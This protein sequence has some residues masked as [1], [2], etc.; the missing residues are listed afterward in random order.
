MTRASE[1]NI[2]GPQCDDGIDNDLDGRIDYK[3]NGLGD[4][5]CLSSL[6]TSETKVCS[7]GIDN[8]NDGLK[9]YP[10]DPGCSSAI[11][12][13]ERGAST[14]CDDGIDNDGDGKIDFRLDGTGDAGCVGPFGI[15]EQLSACEDGIDNDGDSLIDYPGDTG[16]VSKSDS[17]EREAGGLQCDNGTDDD[18]D[19]RIDFPLD[20]G[21]NCACDNSETN[22]AGPQC[23]NGIEDD[24]D[25]KVDYRINGSGD[26]GCSGP[27][28]TSEKDP[29]GPQC[30]NG[31]DD[32]VDG[33]I[34]FRTDGAGDP[35]CFGPTD[36]SEKDPN[37]PQCDNGR[38]DD[39]DGKIDFRVDGAGDLGCTGPTDNTEDTDLVSSPSNLQASDG[40]SPDGVDLSWVG[41]N[42]P[43]YYTIYRSEFSGSPGGPLTNTT[44]AVYKDTSAVPGVIYYYT[45][46]ARVSGVETA[47][48][49]SDSGFRRCP[50]TVQP[51]QVVSPS[52]DPGLA[53][54]SP[55]YTKYN[56]FL[57]MSDFLELINSG[58]AA[59]SLTLTLFTLDGN[60]LISQPIFLAG[61]QQIDVDINSL[62]M[63]GCRQTP[64]FCAAFTDQEPNGRPDGILDSYGLIRLEW[65]HRAANV[66]VSGR[67]SQY[68]KNADGTYSFAYA[69]EL[70]N[71]SFGA[72]FGSSNTID[73]QGG[74]NETPN[75]FEVIN[76]SSLPQVFD[77]LLY[78]QDGDVIRRELITVPPLGERDIQAGH[79]IKDSQGRPTQAGY[80]AE[81][82]PLDGQVPYFSSIARYNS[83]A[84]P[85]EKPTSFNFAFSL[86][87]RQG[88][89]ER[90]YTLIS[91]ERV[92]DPSGQDLSS[93]DSW[94]EVNNVREIPI[95][96]T[97]VFRSGGFVLKT[98]T[99]V[100][101]PKAQFHFDGS[102]PLLK[103]STGSAEI[104]SNVPGAVVATSLVYFHS[105]KSNALQ[106]AYAIAARGLGSATQAGS[107]NTN[108][109][110][111]NIVQLISTSTESNQVFGVVQLFNGNQPVFVN[112]NLGNSSESAQSVSLSENSYGSLMLTSSQFGKFVG[113]VL[114][115]R[116]DKD[117]VDFAMPT[118]VQ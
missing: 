117:G 21:C 6:D 41:I 35:G 96:V 97:V 37:G 9:D 43:D 24:V 116:T 88:T 12:G 113:S 68:L 59:T 70:R 108:L 11:D 118:V 4:T 44:S 40:T 25:G 65:D 39:S 23:D 48:S 53:L 28:D 105:I 51:G 115:L 58:T 7:D 42:N 91:N 45:V 16:C 1:D 93:V 18:G 63:T 62:F 13:N 87:G 36:T 47:P 109:A 30:D 84:R 110:M 19:G 14:Q 111:K 107:V 2:S 71:P 10:S 102:A 46:T 38:D 5:S 95:T 100:L 89:T 86:D 106:S 57:G 34:D 60:K 56:T 50:N 54:K 3:I 55:A 72:T 33:K 75:W 104:T 77:V 99:Q 85:G 76:L 90:L 49:N 8:D 26:P 114:R 66:A 74:S 80:L 69:K 29:N 15:S 31:I 61:G 83:T 101:G 27:T 112:F 73:P 82:R 103:G 92:T 32:D 98:A 81:V 79:E 78:S 67:I 17:S 52:C 64:F 22:A 20:P 94:V